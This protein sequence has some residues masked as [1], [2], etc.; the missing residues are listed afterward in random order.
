MVGTEPW[1]TP[2]HLNIECFL[3]SLGFALFRQDRELGTSGGGVFILVK[4]TLI[5]SEQ[6]QLKT[7]C[8]II[9]V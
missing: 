2:N 6:K 4:D 8:E 9:W 3:K 5:A 7:E 1:L